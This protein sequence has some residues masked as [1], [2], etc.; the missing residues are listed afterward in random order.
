M[1]VDLMRKFF[2][3]QIRSDVPQIKCK[4]SLTKLVWLD[5]AGHSSST[6]LARS[7]LIPLE[8]KAEPSTTARVW[9]GLPGLAVSNPRLQTVT[10]GRG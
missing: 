2:L 9:Q 8:M 10:S 5:R 4:S 7:H 3:A 1:R 6:L